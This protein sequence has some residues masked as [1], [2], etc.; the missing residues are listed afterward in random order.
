MRLPGVCTL[1]ALVASPALANAQ[2]VW[3]G[4]QGPSWNNPANWSTGVVPGPLDD[5][6][7]PAASLAIPSAYS[8]DPV[9][10][11]LTI[12]SGASMAVAP[13]FDLTLTGSLD[14]D[15]A[16][17]F[18]PDNQAVVAGDWI[19]D[20]VFLA[21]GSQLELSGSG[22]IGGSTVNV[23][24]SLVIDG[25]TR[26]AV[27]TF[28][29]EGALTVASGATLDLPFG[30]VAAVNGDWDSSAPNATTTGGG[31]IQL[32]G[33]G[34]LATGDNTI[35]SV[36][37]LGGLRQV[38]GATV[39]G[40]LLQTA[41]VIEVFDNTTFAVG[42][43][44][45]L[46]GGALSFSVGGVEPEIFDVDG[47]ITWAGTAAGAFGDTSQIHCAGDWNANAPFLP[48]AGIVRL[49]GGTPAAMTGLTPTLAGLR[50]VSGVKTLEAGA[51]L[52]GDLRIDD[53][54][55]LLASGVINVE[56]F[57]RLGD[58]TAAWNMG[59]FPHTVAQEYTS[60]GASATNGVLILNGA[61]GTID[62]GTGSVDDLRIVEG[63]W[64]VVSA[65][66]LGELTMSGGDVTLEPSGAMAVAGNASL[67]GGS[68]ALS[69]GSLFDFGG[70]VDVD[71]LA[72]GAM[73]ATSRIEFGG[74]W[75][76]SS[77][78]MPSAGVVVHTGGGAS[79]ITG[80]AAFA[81][82]TN[83]SGTLTA[84]VP[85][86]VS[87]DLTV[88]ADLISQTT[89]IIEGGVAL[90][91]SAIWDLGGTNHSVA[92]D[93][94]SAGGSAVNGL[95]SFT[96]DG[97]F[98]TGSGA[99]DNI[100]VSAG[101]RRAF[102]ATIAVD[103][104]LTDG[105]LQIQDDQTVT[106][107]GNALLTG[108][109]LGWSPAAADGAEV[110]DVRGDVTC[111]SVVA[112]ES[113]ASELRC[114]GNWL[115]D[116]NFDPQALTVYLDGTGPSTVGGAPRFHNLTLQGP[117]RTLTA[118][119][120]VAGDLT[121]ETG[122]VLDAD[123][124]LDVDGSVVLGGPGA[125]FD[126]GAATHT[127]AGDWTSS[128]GVASGDGWIELN[129]AGT[130]DTG[131]GS[132]GNLRIASGARAVRSSQVTGAL[133]LTGGTLSIE[134]DQTLDVGA[135][136]L[137]QA[138]QLAF[139][140]A[141]DGGTSET[142]SVGG[143]VL[144]N[145]FAGAMSD[146]S[147]IRVQGNWSSDGAWNPPAGAVVF[148][149]EASAVAGT[150]PIFHDLVVESG[151][152]TA[153]PTMFVSGDLRVA[154]GQTL[155]AQADFTVLGN[156]LLEPLST[157]DVGAEAHRVSGDWTSLDAAVGGTGTIQ[158]VSAGVTTTGP[159]GV[160]NVLV[161]NGLREMATTTVR[162][163]LSMTSGGLVIKDD[164]TLLV[165]GDASISFGLLEFESGA[166]GLETFQV[167]GDMTLLGESGSTSP[168]S[169]IEVRGNWTSS[170]NWA[171]VDGRVVLA[172]AAVATL[173][174]TDPILPGLELASGSVDV[175]TAASVRLDLTVAS[176]ALLNTQG[177]LDIDGAVALGDATSAWDTG[178]FT[179]TVGGGVTSSGASITGGGRL[180]LD[181]AGPVDLGG[182]S[183]PELRLLAGAHPFGAA[184]VEGDLAMTAGSIDVQSG[185][186]VVVAGNATFTGGALSLASA[187]VLDVEGDVLLAGAT[188]G[189]H[190]A[191]AVLRCGGAWSSDSG[192]APTDGRVVLD[193]AIASTVGGTGLALSDLTIAAGSRTLT[194]AASLR[195]LELLDGT[196]LTTNGAINASGDVALGAGAAVDLGG[197]THT[198]V[199]DW[200]A[201]GGDAANGTLVLTGTGD[202]S[203]GDGSVPGLV[204]S[205]GARTALDATVTGDL[206]LTGGSLLIA[207][208]AT[209]HVEGNAGLIGGTVS[210]FAA[211]QGGDDVF[212]VDGS[213]TCFVAIGTTTG[214]S[215]FRC[216]GDWTASAA[217]ALN[218]GTVELDGDANALLTADLPGATLRA[219]SL[220]I[221]DGRTV[222]TDLALD[223]DELV[224]EAAGRLQVTGVEATMLAG[225]VTVS[226]ELAV[227]VDGR[228]SLG[229]TAVVL[230][231]QSGLLELFGSPAQPAVVAGA[232]GSGFVVSVD[233]AI[234]ATEFRVEDV[235]P[236]GV[237]IS[238]SAN[239]IDLRDG[240]LTSP[241]PAAGSVLLDIRQAAPL[242][243]WRV[244]FEDPLGVGTT[245]VR[246]SGGAPLTFADSAG[247]FAGPA[248]EF[249]PLGLVEWIDDPAVAFFFEAAAGPGVVDLSWTSA[250]EAPTT[251][252]WV[253][254]RA[255]AAGGPF[256]VV[257][258]LPAVG[259]SFY[260]FADTAV[261]SG[262]EY[263]YRLS[264]KKTAGALILQDTD[265][266]TPW[267]AG[268]P[269]TVLSVGP[270]AP[271]GSIQAAVNAAFPG[272][273]VLVQ[274][275]NYAPFTVGPGVGSLRI[276]GDGTGPVVI[277]TTAAPVTIQGLGFL[278]TVELS[279]LE[280]GNPTSP[281]PGVE[282]LS[283]AG[284]VVLD[285][286]AV[287]GGAGMPGLLVRSSIRTAVQRCAIEGTPGARL[288]LGSTA[289]FGRGSLDEIELVGAS[290]A[291]LAGLSPTPTVEPG[292]SLATL[293]GI[294]PDLDAPELVPL[295]VGFTANLDGEPG[296]IFGIAF[297]TQLAWFDL[298]PPWEMV[299]L[300]NIAA[301]PVVLTGVLTGPTSQ[302]FPLPSDGV[303]FG[304]SL[305]LQ[306][307]VV[308]PSTFAL[309]WSNVTSIVLS[310]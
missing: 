297:S 138:G 8:S 217:F 52:T 1:L 73:A 224:I 236:L 219:A 258:D 306:M 294:H 14:L 208:D 41:G 227:G 218:A 235:G 226:G 234:D 253:V 98:S 53:G 78:W 153:I 22:V 66:V 232:A 279:D 214:R 164:Q 250:I 57:V 155:V 151:T 308:Q 292:S 277:D 122:A 143:A 247:N 291:R 240:V 302:P 225:P 184:A 238:D 194:D 83:Q 223:T 51:S 262:Q 185:A 187:G 309:R 310:N 75:N 29:V 68:L 13:G 32:L 304:A 146:D 76:A 263:F 26:L 62:T 154:A 127:V 289:V 273:V 215:V 21:A 177:V 203:T 34:S 93:F 132:V 105:V 166:P 129:G 293:A 299:G 287:R 168:Q 248:F 188:S 256:A 107:L 36:A 252:S 72:A 103:L 192:Y 174:G 274:P 261:A 190:A 63:I 3:V 112:A 230:V 163:D 126:V 125:V 272:A 202:L 70:D 71:G 124:A 221:A 158:F 290:N 300:I 246:T 49:D 106:V 40:G 180:D 165:E 35:P 135:N 178:G 209:L 25:G 228:L 28:G 176:G 82:L 281:N 39:A 259:P 199:G 50:I 144:M 130:L 30:I 97:D 24:G 64:D 267:S 115:S 241:S 90:G 182:G 142:L 31:T 260:A 237:V 23:F 191:G 101:L 197:L 56:G 186:T 229:P 286:L 280:I 59:G 268:L 119:T 257:A 296:G 189:A 211:E 269:P 195:D 276:Y 43:D 110:L 10:R 282:V 134:D 137:L 212:D 99:V 69:E 108:G 162:G 139:L 233:G 20:G 117:A 113:E 152:T 86:L 193:G 94:S 183:L 265:E 171:P 149:G 84:T 89:S 79:S 175:L 48:T 305:A 87:G 245:N 278:D 157:W 148:E 242:T 7:I 37:V 44:A 147:L 255:T 88:D 91:A 60:M 15:G 220:R 121:V 65:F 67:K 301:A 19:N 58:A 95:V 4:S 201:A 116:T 283:C 61:G 16:L 12:E 33:N 100:R 17:A 145:A 167:E 206:S 264:E 159:D 295:G 270:A 271:F 80:L 104:R 11:N 173:G 205:G 42:G 172:P 275:G 288:E 213:A 204:L 169:R 150:G 254:E 9:C 179:H 249:D 160:P 181:G 111:A 136:A 198:V 140:G 74:D 210:W 96:A 216:G 266:A 307:V 38:F 27:S 239:V 196:S 244:D 18:S 54:A 120:L 45:V 92:G 46:S 141:G 6:V 77:T 285:E 200:V 47:S 55:T 170:S 81:D 243:V 156:V 102:D 131:A 222:G 128:G 207:D 298:P 123:A 251:A 231:P 133:E 114:G 5:A 161:S 303:I 118:A 284:V 85:L 2:S 109:E